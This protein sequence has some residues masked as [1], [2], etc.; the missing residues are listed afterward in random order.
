L[1]ILIAEIGGKTIKAE[2]SKAP[3][4]F[5]DTTITTAVIIA[6]R[7]FTLSMFTPQEWEKSSSNVTAKILL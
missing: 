4:S 6:V 2:M 3:T 5:I 7:R 1:Q